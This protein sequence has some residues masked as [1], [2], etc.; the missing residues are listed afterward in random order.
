MFGAVTL[1]ADSPLHFG[2][3]PDRTGPPPWSGPTDRWASHRQKGESR[4]KSKMKPSGIGLEKEPRF[5]TGAQEIGVAK[6]EL[7]GL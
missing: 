6:P 3:A 4:S 5:L 1:E 7:S 2:Y